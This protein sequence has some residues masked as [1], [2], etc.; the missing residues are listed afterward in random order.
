MSLTQFIAPLVPAPRSSTAT[1]LLPG[2]R[3]LLLPLS[4]AI[5]SAAG[6]TSEQGQAQTPGSGPT[7]SPCTGKSISC[8]RLDSRLY[9][10]SQSENTA[11]EA[12]RLGLPVEGG[13]VRVIIELNPG[14]APPNVTGVTIETTASGLVQ[15]LVAPSA[16]C[17]L[18]NAPGVSFVRPALTS[19]GL[20]AAQ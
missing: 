10:L 12:A 9:Q 19:T 15:A 17:D 13:R 5:L 20:G 8:P 4:L 16:L 18:S 11:E 14:A 1:V 7:A 2:A 6:C 3:R